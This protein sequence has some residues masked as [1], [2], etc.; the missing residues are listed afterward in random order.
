M[1]TKAWLKQKVGAG[2]MVK[3]L[4]SRALL[5]RPGV[6]PVWI[7]GVDMALLNRPC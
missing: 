5:Q 6:S 4:S 3:W 2:L 1:L 7:L